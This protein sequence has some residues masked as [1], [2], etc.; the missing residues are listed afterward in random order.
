MW[1]D[2]QGAE[3]MVL[4]GGQRFLKRSNLYRDFYTS[5]LY[6]KSTTLEEVDEI[7]KNYGFTLVLLGTDINLTGNALFIKNN[8]NLFN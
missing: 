3:K 7:L 4:K 8:K 6:K 1:I 5:E 2:V